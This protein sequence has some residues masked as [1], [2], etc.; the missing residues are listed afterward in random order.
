MSCATNA[1]A[2]NQTRRTHAARKDSHTLFAW[3]DTFRMDAADRAAPVAPSGNTRQN[4]HLDV[5][6]ARAV[7]ACPHLPDIVEVHTGTKPQALPHAPASR[8]KK[9]CPETVGR[10]P[11]GVPRR[12]ACQ[13]PKFEYFGARQKGHRNLGAREPPRRSRNESRGTAT[14]LAMRF[15]NARTKR[16]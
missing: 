10:R 5:K 13:N 6:C 8:S 15:A 16:I 3:Q 2:L 14:A 1:R 11:A 7:F 4:R 12:L 9:L